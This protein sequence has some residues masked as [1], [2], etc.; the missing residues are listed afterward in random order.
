MMRLLARCNLVVAYQFL[1]Y[2]FV[3]ALYFVAELQLVQREAVVAE[4]LRRLT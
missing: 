3:V 2:F 4:W 1:F